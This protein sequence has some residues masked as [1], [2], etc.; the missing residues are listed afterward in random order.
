MPRDGFLAS[1]A[2]HAAAEFMRTAE[3]FLR[4]S[5]G[6]KCCLQ[7]G[8]SRIRADAVMHFMQEAVEFSVFSG[9]GADGGFVRAMFTIV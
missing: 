5:V 6:R 2:W 4:R 3:F 1:Q 7:N 9:Q 8:I